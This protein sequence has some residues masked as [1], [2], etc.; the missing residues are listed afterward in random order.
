MVLGCGA[1]MATSRSAALVFALSFCSIAAGCGARST[2][3]EGDPNAGSA[4]VALFAPDGSGCVDEPPLGTAVEVISPADAGD[5]IAVVDITFAEEC[6]DLGG[7]YVLAR[8]LD[9]VKR[10]WLGGHGC[11]FLEQFSN[12]LGLVYGVVRYRVTAGIS[13]IPADVCV[14]FPDE[15]PGMETDSTTLGIAVFETLSGAQAFADSL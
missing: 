12:T 14:G 13:Q 6:T 9:G 2:V 1:A 15:T 11:Q 7:Q 10:Y 3:L 8:D 5:E 4:P